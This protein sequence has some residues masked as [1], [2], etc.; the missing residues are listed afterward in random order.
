MLTINSLEKIDPKP[1]STTA[2]TSTQSG[3]V[4]LNVVLNGVQNQPPSLSSD[5]DIETIPQEKVVPKRNSSK[6]LNTVISFPHQF[7]GLSYTLVNSEKWFYSIVPTESK[8]VKKID[9]PKI[10]NLK[11]EDVHLEKDP[12]LKTIRDAI[13]DRNPQ[14]KEIIVKLGQNYAQH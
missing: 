10:I 13:R 5:S 3:N 14:A 1:P 2:N 9:Y 7:P 8:I 11:L 6:N 4:D 12:I